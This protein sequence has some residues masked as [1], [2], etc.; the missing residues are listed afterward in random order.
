MCSYH[1]FDDIY[2]LSYNFSK[3][4]IKFLQLS[5][6]NTN[7]LI[8]IVIVPVTK[9]IIAERSQASNPGRT[10]EMGVVLYGSPSSFWY[11]YIYIYIYVCVCVHINLKF[12]LPMTTFHDTTYH[13]NR[14]R[15]RLQMNLETIRLSDR[16]VV[17]MLRKLSSPHPFVL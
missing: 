5:T 10:T 8:F 16:T 7:L 12:L 15:V 2:F 17:K 13:T 9:Y 4:T 3:Q 11:I 6:F 14:F 1:S